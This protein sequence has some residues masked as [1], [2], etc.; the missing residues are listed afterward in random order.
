MFRD[1]EDFK[2]SVDGIY[3]AMLIG[4]MTCMDLYVNNNKFAE[5]KEEDTKPF[6][7]YI[8]DTTSDGIA[9][10]IIETNSGKRFTFEGQE[11]GYVRLEES[12]QDD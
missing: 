10:L 2:S 1:D 8:R 4:V 9:D 12:L 5:V 6:S 3:V 11:G 7:I